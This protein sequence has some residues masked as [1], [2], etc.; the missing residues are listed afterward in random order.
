MQVRKTI[1]SCQT[2]ALAGS[3][4]EWEERD[5]NPSADK[6]LVK[7]RKFFS[8]EVPQKVHNNFLNTCKIHS[9]KVSAVAVHTL[10]T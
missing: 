5:S 4:A 1:G 3:Q 9:S 7:L 10:Y 2:Q 8:E 6:A